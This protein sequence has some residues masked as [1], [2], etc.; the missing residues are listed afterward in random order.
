[1]SLNVVTSAWLKTEITGEKFDG[2]EGLN[3]FV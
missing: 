2:A 3:M 1:M